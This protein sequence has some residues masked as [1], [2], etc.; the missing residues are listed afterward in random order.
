MAPAI[1]SY[2]LARHIPDAQLITYPG[3]GHGFLFQYPS[4]FLVYAAR[5]PGTDAA[6]AGTCRAQAKP[7]LPPAAAAGRKG[8]EHE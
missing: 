5:F 7:H 8:A 1:N 3:S 2:I 4:L 6:I